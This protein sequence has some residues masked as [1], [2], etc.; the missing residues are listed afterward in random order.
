MVERLRR[1]TP[2]AQTVSAGVA[3]W[4]A[5]EPAEAL[6]ARA[7][8]ARCQAKRGGRNRVVAAP[9]RLAAS[10]PSSSRLASGPPA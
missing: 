9:Q 7:D 1:A 2:L 6:P 10:S 8:R 4:D 5:A 3:C